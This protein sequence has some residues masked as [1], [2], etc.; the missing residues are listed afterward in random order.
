M[1]SEVASREEHPLVRLLEDPE[2]LEHYHASD[3]ARRF[4][5]LYHEE[6]REAFAHYL[7]KIPEE[8]LG[9]LLLEL[10]E[11]LRDAAL[12]ALSAEKLSEAVD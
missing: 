12:E 11:Y 3:L 4:K 7:R 1:G 9:E 6:G 5:E 10:P 8:Q 2:A